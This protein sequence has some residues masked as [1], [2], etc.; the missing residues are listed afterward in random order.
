LKWSFLP[1][2]D[3]GQR[4]LA[5]NAD[6]SEPG[7]F[8]DRLLM[9]FDPHLVLEGIAICLL[10]LPPEQGVHLHPRRVSPPGHVLEEAH[11]GGVRPR[12]LR[13]ARAC[14]T[15][16]TPSADAF[17]VEVL[18][19]PRRGRVHLRRGDGAAGSDRG[20]AR[21]AAHQAAL[22]GGQGPL[23][24]PTIIN[25]VETLAHLPSIIEHGAEWFCEAGRASRSVAGRRATAP[26]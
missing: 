17:Q 22:P 21:L 16:A 3:G 9:D 12:H 11:Q 4:Y 26:S 2:A 7:T 25:N 5:I 20:Q 24:R 13:R 19:P 1:P 6:E 15:A 10:R 14:T 18:R 8:K 23:R